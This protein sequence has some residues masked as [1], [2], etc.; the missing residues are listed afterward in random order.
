MQS[1]H[2]H[3]RCFETTILSPRTFVSAPSTTMM[4]G[5]PLESL[6]IDPASGQYISE[7]SPREQ[8]AFWQ[9][10]VGRDLCAFLRQ[11]QTRLVSGPFSA[12]PDGFCP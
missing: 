8:A 11:V 1:L 3:G 4:P 5:Y 2:P 10:T 6:Q 12:T 7:M 9:R